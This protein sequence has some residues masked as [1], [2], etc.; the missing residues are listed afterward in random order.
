MIGSQWAQF[1][2]LALR[3]C[4]VCPLRKH[5]SR[6]E[7]LVILPIIK[8]VRLFLYVY[9]FPCFSFCDGFCKFKCNVVFS[10]LLVLWEYRHC[11]LF[12]VYHK[13]DV[14]TFKTLHLSSLPKILT[15]EIWKFWRK[16]YPTTDISSIK[17]T[18]ALVDLK[19]IK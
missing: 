2:W 17:I 10:C 13:V 19:K 15:L 5:F 14:L 12:S 6:I 16:A 7:I 1:H 11:C 8:A 3:C 9:G 4:S 18:L